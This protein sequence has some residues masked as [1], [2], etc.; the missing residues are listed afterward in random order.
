[1]D[2][3]IRGISPQIALIGQTNKPLVYC[4]VRG[5]RTDSSFEQLRLLHSRELR[6]SAIRCAII[7]D[8]DADWD[9]GSGQVEL[10]IEA[11]VGAFG[12]SGHPSM[13]AFA[14]HVT[15]L[16]ALSSP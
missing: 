1:M 7:W 13:N 12:G 15:I 8:V 3:L 11:E 9:D 14:F 4:S 16:A 10:R 5:L 6:P 2:N